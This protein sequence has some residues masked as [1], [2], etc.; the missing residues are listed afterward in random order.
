MRGDSAVTSSPAHSTTSR[1]PHTVRDAGR[2]DVPPPSPQ[3]IQTELVGQFSR[4]HGVRQILFVSEN[5]QHGIPQL[6]LLELPEK[7]VQD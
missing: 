2:L 7:I 6:I 4:A 5:Q 1:G 3:L